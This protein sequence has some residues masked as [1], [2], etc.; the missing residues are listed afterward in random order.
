MPTI[1]NHEA[2]GVCLV[3]GAR[4][5]PT[6]EL[7][8]ACGR[9]Q[10]VPLCAA[11]LFAVVAAQESASTAREEARRPRRRRE[12]HAPVPD[13]ENGGGEGAP[14]FALPIVASPAG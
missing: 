2:K 4:D 6:L 8:T 3:C 10:G 7:T 14:V 1:A 9:L 11:C 12:V 5:T 13:A